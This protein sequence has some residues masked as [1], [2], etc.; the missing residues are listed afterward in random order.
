MKCPYCNNNNMPSPPKSPR[1]FGK[2][3]DCG[4]KSRAAVTLSKNGQIYSH[5]SATSKAKLDPA[6]VKKVRSFR[7]ADNELG[8]IEAGTLRL[9]V[10]N[11]RITIAV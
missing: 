2:C 8:A 6:D 9:V 1:P 11:R 4:K 3:P 10:I 7:A 5:Y